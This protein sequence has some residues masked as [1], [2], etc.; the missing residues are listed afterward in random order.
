VNAV[1]DDSH[2]TRVALV[3]KADPAREQLRHALL[4]RGALLVFEGDVEECVRS[5]LMRQPP[6]VLIVSLVAGVEDEI[7]NLQPLLDDA[8]VQVV[9][10]DGEASSQLSGWDLDRWARHL[11]AKVLGAEDALPPRPAG[12]ERV[13]TNLGAVPVRAEALPQQKVPTSTPMQAKAEQGLDLASHSDGQSVEPSATL[14]EAGWALDASPEVM[15]DFDFTA[16]MEE[17]GVNLQ[18][19]SSTESRDDVTDGRDYSAALTSDADLDGL[20]A[21]DSERFEVIKTREAAAKAESALSD[22]PDQLMR[23]LKAVMGLDDHSV[24]LP[25]R[26]ANRFDD[27]PQ[28]NLDSTGDSADD[29][30]DE[31]LLALFA[32]PDADS[33][34]T[35]PMV[36]ESS[37]SEDDRQA[38]SSGSS[39]TLEPI[40]E[41][42]FAAIEPLQPAYATEDQAL[43][44]AMTTSEQRGG[45]Q[46]TPPVAEDWST[47][48]LSLSA[49]DQAL[50]QSV[51][52]EWNGMDFAP[53][54]SDVTGVPQPLLGAEETVSRQIAAVDPDASVQHE[55][56]RLEAEMSALM[57]VRTFTDEVRELEFPAQP[58]I[59]VAAEAK[60]ESAEPS[61]AAQPIGS[62]RFGTLSLLGDDEPIQPAA[63]TPSPAVAKPAFNFDQ[64]GGGLSLVPMDTSE[65]PVG[66]VTPSSLPNRGA[67]AAVALLEAHDTQVAAASVAA[68][69]S[70][71]RVIVLGASIGGPDALRTFLAGFDADFN[72]AFLVAQHLE[73]GFF[74]RLA[75][76]LQKSTKLNVSVPQEGMRLRHGMVWVIPSDRRFTLAPDGTASFSPHETPPRYRPCIDDILR[77]AA[78]AF[79]KATT[80]L[81]FSGMA[82]DAIEGAVY[83]ADK[84]GEVWVQD[85]ETCVVSSMVDGARARG[86]VDFVGSPAELASHCVERFQLTL[87]SMAESE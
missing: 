8:D 38:W 34:A 50:L 44:A 27:S 45:V 1:I 2:Q 80:A 81:V 43:P 17:A 31:D 78:D 12:A 83:L 56:A 59:T 23:S 32:S 84:G 11:V 82:A 40:D 52:D 13:V 73:N 63:A 19:L 25:Q 48:L 5:S 68:T 21:G 69:G 24:E 35:A 9:F 67:T 37:I 30:S 18:E 49:E 55:L 85:P 14:S 86:V 53:I 33:A 76:Q 26:A 87:D 46:S 10:D 22:D 29:L 16:A 66:E 57:G 72:A 42:D 58:S 47:A 20:S 7:E 54:A 65:D 62:Q 4:A 71:Q 70:L 61:V 28:V 6:D 74:E 51:E 60:M 75:Q 36:A 79:G 77:S 64:L 3:G 41:F 15:D 39:L